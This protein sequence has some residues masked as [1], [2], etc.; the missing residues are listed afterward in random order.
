M[1]APETIEIELTGGLR[2]RVSE[3]IGTQALRRIVAASPR[4]ASAGQQGSD[5]R[6]RDIQDASGLVIRGA[7]V[8]QA[9]WRDPADNNPNSRKP[10]MV[11]GARSAR[12]VRRTRARGWSIGAEVGADANTVSKWR[13]RFAAHRLDGLVDRGPARRE[14]SATMRSPRP[15]A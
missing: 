9:C 6:R 5:I 10:R 15:S 4:R 7:T 8:L 2:L 11:E 12:C 3:R 1:A 14:R 13:R